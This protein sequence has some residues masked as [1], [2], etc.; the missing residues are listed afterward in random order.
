MY[1]LRPTAMVNSVNANQN[2]WGYNKNMEN[3]YNRHHGA[4]LRSFLPDDLVYATKQE[5]NRSSWVPATVRDQ[6]SKVNYEVEI[7]G[8]T[9]RKH[10][11]QL[12]PRYSPAP[13]MTEIEDS[14]L[15]LAIRLPRL[16]R[17]RTRPA[18]Q[19][20]KPERGETPKAEK[21]DPLENE[22]E[23]EESLVRLSRAIVDAAEREAKARRE[24][25]QTVTQLRQ[26]VSQP[27]EKQT[28]QPGEDQV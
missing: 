13:Q 27:A 14:L 4:K 21:E 1:L 20:E 25:I 26:F 3:D 5:G 19:P 22:N 28:K 8:K 17:R 2:S 24:A 18:P 7:D 23:L 10:A 9:E 11:N 6:Y 16:R 15:Q 12:K